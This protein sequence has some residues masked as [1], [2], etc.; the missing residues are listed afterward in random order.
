MI[1]LNEI[2]NRALAFSKE[3]EREVNEDA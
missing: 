1:T 3:W 2:R